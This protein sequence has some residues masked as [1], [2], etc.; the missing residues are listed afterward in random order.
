MPQVELPLYIVY[1]D[2]KCPDVDGLTKSFEKASQLKVVS[3]EN[4]QSAGRSL[5]AWLANEPKPILVM[6]AE[7]R[8]L[9]G[10][11]CLE[12][13]FQHRKSTSLWKPIE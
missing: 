11:D 12:Y 13:L 10:D 2:K 9:S 7:K 6:T 5:P 3:I 8:G 1:V 4:L